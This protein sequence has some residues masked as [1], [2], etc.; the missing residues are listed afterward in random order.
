MPKAIPRACRKIGCAGKTTERHGYCPAHEHEGWTQHQR[1]RSK[2]QRGYGSTWKHPRER[3]L[4]R[5][6]YLCVLCLKRG[7]YKPAN[8]V[9]HIIPKAHGG[10]DELD[11]LQSLCRCCDKQKTARE[12]LQA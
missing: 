6:N 10:M 3:A 11:N 8:V 12:R 4:K 9:D 2:E 5:D 1:G 7:I